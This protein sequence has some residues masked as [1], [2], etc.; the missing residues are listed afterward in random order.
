MLGFGSMLLTFGFD[1]FLSNYL[2]FA[3]YFFYIYK[4]IKYLLLQYFCN[5]Y[6]NNDLKMNKFNKSLTSDRRQ[7]CSLFSSWAV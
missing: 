5:Q 6:F 7:Y 1:I 3:N 2:D 4:V